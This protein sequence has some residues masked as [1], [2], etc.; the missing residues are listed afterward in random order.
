MEGR[1]RTTT[2]MREINEENRIELNRKREGIASRI[3][4]CEELNETNENLESRET[5]FY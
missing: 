1:R 2:T 3:G 4:W 5:R